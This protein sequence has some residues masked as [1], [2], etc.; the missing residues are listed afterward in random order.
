[1]P[2][3]S[4]QLNNLEVFKEASGVVTLKNATLDSSVTINAGSNVSGIGQLIGIS[5]VNAFSTA[6]NTVT[7]EPNKSYA[8]IVAMY[9]SGGTSAVESWTIT[10]DSS[11]NASV[12]QLGDVYTEISIEAATGGIRLADSNSM[13][14]GYGSAFIFEQGSTFDASE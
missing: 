2:N 12:T 8:A 10:T 1:M 4:F 13:S 11:N 6:G 3:A 14:Y 5:Y 7:T 9:K